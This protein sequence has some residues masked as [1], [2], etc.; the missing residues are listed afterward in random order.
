[1]LMVGRLGQNKIESMEECRVTLTAENGMETQ[2]D[3]TLP[4]KPV[5]V[6]TF[7]N[8]TIY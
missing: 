4:D 5:M 2:A 6:P 8:A 1:M 3:A 7:C